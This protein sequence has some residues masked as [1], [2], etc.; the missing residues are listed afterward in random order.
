MPILTRYVLTEMIKVFL[1]ALAGMTLFFL[2]FGV[3]KL[4]YN[5]GLGLKQV[6]LLIPY[7]LPDA[8]RFSVPA[9]ILFAACSVFGRLASANE[10]TAVKASGISPMVLL[11]PAFVLAFF[12]SLGAVWL[13][14]VAVSWGYD[15]ATRVVIEAVEEIAY[16]RLQQQHAYSA[17]QFSINVADVD[18]K[19]L[20]R[21]T[22]TLQGDGDQPSTTIICEVATLRTD[23]AAQTLN[24]SC[25]NCTVEIGDGTL[26]LPHLDRAIPLNE[27][28]HKSGSGSSPSYLP[29][30]VIPHERVEQLNLIQKLQQQLAAKAACQLI[31]GD[32]SQLE[33]WSGGQS[34][35]T[36]AQQRLYRLQMEHSRRWANGFSC[37]CFVLLGAPLAIRMRNSD[38]LSSFFM[39]FLPILICYY[40]L[41]ILGVSKAKA[42]F[43]PC[44]GVWAGNVILAIVGVHFMR[45][46][47]QR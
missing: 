9:T 42:G 43:F 4:A 23:L 22:I 33:S 20:I 26:D 28:S 27:A 2:L 13:N 15:G 24:I 35:L 5:E 44:W 31:C 3:V 6:L 1:V 37:L 12:I 38:F 11:W 17:K 18:G 21:P 8:M 46:V 30:N 14:D 7:V 29:M 25:D 40:P 41:L 10:V 34:E 19:R 36:E 47:Y 16:G 32:F 45:R 39:C